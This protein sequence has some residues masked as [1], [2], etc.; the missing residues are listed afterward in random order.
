MLIK[1]CCDFIRNKNCL[2]IIKICSKVAHSQ[3]PYEWKGGCW[4][5]FM[6]QEEKKKMSVDGFSRFVCCFLEATINRCC[7]T[8]T[9]ELGIRV[10]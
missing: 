7:R 2:A 3:Q 6:F 8:H 4:A 9:G 5:T 1:W 10:A